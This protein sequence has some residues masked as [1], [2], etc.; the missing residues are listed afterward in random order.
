MPEKNEAEEEYFARQNREQQAKLAEQVAAEKI[1]AE[2]AELK[3]VHAQ[4]CGKC[5]GALKP[6]NFRG[7]EIDVCEDCHAVLLDPGELEAL[8]GA[9]ESGAVRSLAALFSFGKKK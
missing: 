2:R 5:G 7:V 9:D 6:Q 1:V 8:A 3:R 4:R